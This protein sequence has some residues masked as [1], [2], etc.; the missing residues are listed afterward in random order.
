MSDSPEISLTRVRS[1]LVG[2]ED[3][4]CDGSVGGRQVAVELHSWLSHTIT[5]Q[6]NMSASIHL[7][8]VTPAPLQTII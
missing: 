8:L 2:D 5:S 1:Y 4:A 3:E 6:G 7:K